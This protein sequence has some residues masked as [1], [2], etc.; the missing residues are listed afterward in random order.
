MCL[1]SWGTT[2]L[3]NSRWNVA[4]A[5]VCAL[6]WWISLRPA[7]VSQS[8][9]WIIFAAIGVLAAYLMNVV[10]NVRTMGFDGRFRLEY[11][12][13]GITLLDDEQGFNRLNGIDLMARLMA[14]VFE[15]GPAWGTAWMHILWDVRR[16][17][18]PAGFD[19]FRL[20]LETNAKSY[21]MTHYLGWRVADYYSC[22][23][24]D[25]FGNFGLIGFPIGALVVGLTSS[26]SCAG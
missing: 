6:G 18:D 19:E 2:A 8:R 3:L 15:E 9:T 14:P 7:S 12:T 4:I 24:T 25:L 10:M 17:V 5:C 11:L 21:L 1:G 22:M 20:S 23:M 16:L 13:P 26:A